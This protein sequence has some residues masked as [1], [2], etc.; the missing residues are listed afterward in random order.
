MKY[1]ADTLDQGTGAIQQENA[2]SATDA[3]PAR[4]T[5]SMVDE[6]HGK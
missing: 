6:A 3:L 2:T 5:G 1:D 4:I